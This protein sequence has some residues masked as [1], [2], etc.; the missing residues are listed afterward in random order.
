MGRVDDAIS[1]LTS[2]SDGSGTLEQESYLGL[3][4]V[5]TRAHPQPGVDLTNAK[6]EAA[7]DRRSH[8]MV[9]VLASRGPRVD[10]DRFVPLLDA[11][12]GRALPAYQEIPCPTFPRRPCRR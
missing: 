7:F 8:L 12:L 6:L 10:T 9:G 3:G 4:T 5:V 11:A 1:R 2:L